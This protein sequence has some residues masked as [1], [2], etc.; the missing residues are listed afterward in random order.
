MTSSVGSRFPEPADQIADAMTGPV[1]IG[2]NEKSR[3]DVAFPVITSVPVIA[4]SESL[5]AIV[6]TPGT[7]GVENVVILTTFERAP[8]IVGAPPA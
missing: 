5:M 8:L 6:V 4:P 1:T 3:V 2:W 7:G